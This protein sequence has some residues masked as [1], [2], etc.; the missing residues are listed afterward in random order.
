MVRGVAS[1]TGRRRGGIKI[2]CNETCELGLDFNSSTEGGSGRT[3]YEFKHVD[4]DL[5]SPT[6]FLRYSPDPA[7]MTIDR[8]VACGNA[9]VALRT[10]SS[11]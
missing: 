3:N 5:N 7:I 2:V 11:M 10:H 6:S 8:A 1:E 9:M 4:F